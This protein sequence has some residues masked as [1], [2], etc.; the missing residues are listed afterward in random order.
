MRV[1]DLESIIIEPKGKLYSRV[2][3]NPTNYELIGTGNQGAVFKISSDK[4][5]KIYHH[6][7]HKEDEAE[8][9][10]DASDSPYFPDL[11]ETGKNYIIMEYIDGPTLEEYL[12]QINKLPESITDQILDLF[13]EM[14]RLKFTR[15]DAN[16]R[17]L[18]VTKDERIKCIDHCHSRT[19]KVKMPEKLFKKLNRVGLLEEFVNQIKEKDIE[20]YNK[21]KGEIKKYL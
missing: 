1:K 13:K 15:I 3:K 6:Q 8:V 11:Y 7:R 12:Q 14:K 20:S 21:W 17:H 4:C 2:V 9:L 19:K 10:R 5:A 16:L 18:L